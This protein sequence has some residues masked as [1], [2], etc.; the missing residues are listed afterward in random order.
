MKKLDRKTVVSLVVVLVSLLGVYF[1]AS[2]VVPRILVSVS[3]SAPGVTVSIS[4]SYVL[5]GKILA[6]AD[7]KD[8]NV[9]NVFLMD[10]SGK[11]VPDKSV[12]L[13]GMDGIVP[14][15]GMTDAM[16]KVS[17]VMSSNEEGQFDIWAN[18]EGV[19]L[20]QGVTVTFR[21]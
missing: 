17:F 10:K 2:I 3:Q 8:E 20:P 1:L 18:A 21:N 5:G 4:D 15:M 9:V 6:K 13:I 14:E 7:G 16:G 11:G 19:D 12:R